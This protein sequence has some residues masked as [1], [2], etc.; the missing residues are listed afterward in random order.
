[1]V[2]LPDPEAP[3]RT[4]NGGA[5]GATQE[6][7]ALGCSKGGPVRS[8]Q[9]PVNSSSIAGK[10]SSHACRSPWLRQFALSCSGIIIDP[11][12]RCHAA[13]RLSNGALGRTAGSKAS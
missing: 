9:R 12:E 7:V 8:D 3:V 2:V 4:T 6:H 1:M 11:V 5:M 13:G 10:L